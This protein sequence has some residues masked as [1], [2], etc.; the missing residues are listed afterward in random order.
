MVATRGSIG[1][2]RA[3]EKGDE[4][5]LR[6]LVRDLIA[7]SSLQAIWSR[8]DA[9]QIAEGLA[10]L[11]VS[12]L[13]AEFASVVLQDP[14]VDIAHFHDRNFQPEFPLSFFRK[15]CYPIP[16]KTVDIPGFGRLHAMSVPIG[17]EPESALVCF[18]KR[19]TFPTESERT[20]ARVAANHACLALQRWRGEQVL[21]D[22]TRQLEVQSETNA[23]LFQ[24]ADAL[25]RSVSLD[26][27]IGAGLDA[28]VSA[29][30]C[31][32]AS[33]LLFDSEGV[34]RF[35]G[36]RGLS[37][38]YRAAVEGHCPWAA[39]ERNAQPIL[40]SDIAATDV[41]D[42]LKAVIRTEGISALAFIPIMA[43]GGVIGKFMT[44]Y[45][46]P[47]QFSDAERALAVTIARQLGFSIE[48][49]RAEQERDAA[50][51]ALRAREELRRSEERFRILVEGVTDYA[52]FMLDEN[53]NVSNWNAG[54][55][56]IKQYADDEIIGQHFSIFY[57]E[58]DRVGGE[59]ERA[60]R[61]AR[62]EGRF[63]SESRRVRK[64]G[65]QFWAHVV[66]DPIRNESGEIIG[67]AKI[68]RDITERREAQLALEA[69]REAF[70]QSQKMEAIGQLT[71]GIAHDFNNLLAA[72][73]GSLQLL[74]K[75]L[76]DD[77]KA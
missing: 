33:I 3:R 48:R 29:F 51:D 52:I 63:E 66:L 2:E 43:N 58:D 36:W 54:A 14:P 6:P 64:D 31:R 65:T 39:G 60:L 13:D 32:R 4:R 72:V 75:R 62:E 35:V 59:P 44:Y 49:R 57:T 18:S 17:T 11:V 9:R 76:P 40:V 16:A 41:S 47:H 19:E 15:H 45:G 69:A 21:Q 68:T 10:Q 28:I 24:F 70:F 27:A 71:G 46:H 74:R 22:R 30:S 5:D 26:D 42:A 56:R 7:L 20:L 25:Y 38:Q 67:F 37:E 50:Q 53:G 12:M 23:A 55:R 1:L 61:I 73:L 77:A 34:A 8:A